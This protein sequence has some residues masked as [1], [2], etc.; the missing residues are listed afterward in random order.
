[1]WG[2]RTC[3]PC[4][5]LSAFGASALC[6]LSFLCL[7][8]LYCARVRHCL[9]V[10]LSIHAYNYNKR[11]RTIQRAHVPWSVVDAEDGTV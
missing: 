3:L 2:A 11:K 1:M 8:F 10:S 6:S 5:V 7:L 9:L 4:A